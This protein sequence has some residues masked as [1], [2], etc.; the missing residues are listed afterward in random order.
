[1]NYVTKNCSRLFIILAVM[2]FC[3]SESFCQEPGSNLLLAK[4]LSAAYVEVTEKVKPAVVTIQCIDLYTN[5]A[6][7]DSAESD[8]D[9]PES[10]L[11]EE[12][13][14]FLSRM[15]ESTAEDVSP[16]SCTGTGIILSADGIVVTNYHVV[17][18]AI[19]IKVKLDT[20]KQLEAEVV[21]LDPKTDLAV[22]K[23]NTAEKLPSATL[24]DSAACKVGSIVIAIGAPEGF[25]QSVTF[26]HISALQRSSE[27]LYY[28]DDLV[29]LNF[30]QTDA[31]INHGNSGGPLVTL[32]G[33]I[34]GINSVGSDDADNL[35]FAIPVNTVK[36]VVEKILKYGEVPRGYMGVATYEL[37]NFS[38]GE[39]Q[40]G[41][42]VQKVHP[43]T[44]AAAAGF[45]MGDILLRYNGTKLESN[46]QVLS[47]VSD[48]EIG[49]KALI[50]YIR[51][52]HHSSAEITITAQPETLDR[53]AMELLAPDDTA[54]QRPESYESELLGITVVALPLPDGFPDDV[55][56]FKDKTG[57]LITELDNRLSACTS[58][59]IP[60]M[61]IKFVNFTEVKTIADL[62][63][64]EKN[65]KPAAEVLIQSLLND[66]IAATSVLDLGLDKKL[67]N[68]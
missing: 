6:E 7:E 5:S 37:R 17:K 53:P 43:N 3:I 58:G 18:D 29:Y 36:N 34:I 9:A 21:G 27:D 67:N 45:K 13:H 11:P 10:M 51:N 52:G 25:E 50:E 68:Q 20:G 24:G 2:G 63:Q 46:Q 15:Q 62:Q 41:L 14:R 44:P 55:E 59:L 28:L 49:S 19:S 26:G 31:A 35:N 48:S 64:V 23:L 65:I 57:L 61:I 33:E 12:V 60:G 8:A 66:D 1:M 56:F 54:Y 32:D 40:E 22:L 38:N 16:G 42:L 47:L 39:V 4:Q 30:I